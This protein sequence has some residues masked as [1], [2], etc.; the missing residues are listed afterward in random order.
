VCDVGDKVKEE[1]ADHDESDEALE[2]EDVDE[3]EIRAYEMYVCLL[4]QSLHHC[5]VVLM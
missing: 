4:P 1:T 2:D 5:N 3:Y